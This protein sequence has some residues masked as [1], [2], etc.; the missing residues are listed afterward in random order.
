MSSNPIL[1]V[2]RVYPAVMWDY[3]N[4]G[5]SIR[6]INPQYFSNSVWRLCATLQ[7]R[8][9]S[10]LSIDSGRM[11]TYFGDDMPAARCL[12]LNSYLIYLID[13]VS[14]HL[15]TNIG[16]VKMLTDVVYGRNCLRGASFLVFSLH[17][18]TCAW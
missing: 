16:D 12:I 5:A 2:G 15:T 6:M 10:V 3:F 4:N 14:V 9:E 13:N 11:F 18:N 1:Y 17:R 8:I 7:V